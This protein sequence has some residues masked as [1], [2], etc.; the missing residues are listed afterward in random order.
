LKAT[1]PDF[2]VAKNKDGSIDKAT[3][4]RRAELHKA[5]VKSQKILADAQAKEYRNKI[6]K[7]LLAVSVLTVVLVLLWFMGG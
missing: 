3:S 5:A 4:V 1:I 2:E 6:V 7:S